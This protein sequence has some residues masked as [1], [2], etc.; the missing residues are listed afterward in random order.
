MKSVIVLVIC[1]TMSFASHS[2]NWTLTWSDEFNGTS[3]NLSDW[4]YDLG[5]GSQYGLWGWGN[6]EL[7]YYLS[8]NV[9]VADGLLTITAQDESF[10][11]MDYTSG[12]IHTK[13]KQN[14]TYGKI[15]ARIKVPTDQGTWPAFWMLKDPFDLNQNSGGWP[16]EIDIMETVGHSSNTAYCTAHYNTPENVISSGGSITLP[17]GDYG[18]DFHIYTIEWYPD[19]IEWFVDG[20]LVH[21]LNKAQIHPIEWQFDEP[22]FLILNLAIG[23][24]WPGAPDGSTTFPEAMEVDWVRVY[25]YDESETTDVT[26]RVDMSDESLNAGDIVYVNGTWNEWCG[27]CNPMQDMG[28]GIWEVTLPIQHG[29][30]EYKYTTN[31]WSG[32]IE[33][34][35]SGMPC[36]LTTTGNP[37]DFVNRVVNVQFDPIVLTPVCFNSC[38]LCPGFNDEG[39]TAPLA[40]NYDS[41]A[42]VDDGSCLF[43]VDFQVD[44][45][46]ESLN[47]GDVVYLNGSFNG[48]CGGCNPLSDGDQDGIWDGTLTLPE[49]AHEYK[50]TTNGW[51]GLIEQFEVGESCTNT[52]YGGA[53]EVWT[54]RIVNLGQSPLDLEAVCFNSCEACQ[55][56]INTVDLTFRVDMY[57]QAVGPEGV[58]LMGDFQDWD[59]SANL[60]SPSGYGLYE[61]TVT[62]VE[63]QSFVFAFVNGNQASDKEIVVGTCASGGNRS[64]LVDSANP[65]LDIVCFA[66]CAQCEGCQNAD[67]AE[68]NPYAFENNGL[69]QTI[70]MPGCTYIGASNYDSTANVEN[71]TCEFDLDNCP[72]DIN[73]DQVVNT[74]DLLAFLSAFGQSCD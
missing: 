55:V 5:T 34:F 9:S 74:E 1:L 45:T 44:M 67:Y 13:T 63:G 12:K 52:T 36:T 64:V 15:E 11:G 65:I 30:H 29:V 66:E 43:A 32:L 48:W 35:A 62:L 47:V 49:G 41:L 61:T 72:A 59:P 58:H 73:D 25:D 31:G 38:D 16:P 2:Q 17:N 50:F 27:T 56:V 24:S 40:V 20:A 14:F 23:G 39:C 69:C 37:D 60:M 26:F 51:D 10:G 21:S 53:G 33:S 7:Q 54:N 22:F 70:A 18:D 4:N 28:N 57:N 6:G 19:N 8:D 68:Y 46:Q 3:L 42:L 71:G